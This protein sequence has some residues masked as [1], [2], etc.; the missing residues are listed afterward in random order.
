VLLPLAGCARSDPADRP[1]AAEPSPEPTEDARASGGAL[2]V[3]A[4]QPHAIDPALAVDP[5]DL[6]ITS[7]L[8]DPLTAIAPDGEVV[9]AAASRWEADEDGSVWTFH[10]RPGASFH[11]G[12]PVSAGAFADAWRRVADRTH[13]EPSPSHR[14]LGAVRGVDAA[15]EGGPLAGVEALDELTLRVT[16]DEPSVEF[17]L[18]VSHPALAP[19]PQ[20][21]TTE[22][23]F[24]RMPVGNGPFRMAEP[25]QPNQYI[26]LERNEDHPV[27]PALDH[28]VF[29]IYG[30]EDAI[31]T[32]YE[33]FA[34]GSL[35]VA[36]V[37]DTRRDQAEET[38]GR[39]PDGYQGPGLL[40]GIRS[41]SVF[42]AF[43]VTVPP[44]DQP[45]VRRAIA[46]LVDRDAL[47]RV[48]AGGGRAAA[49]SVVPPAP[50]GRATMAACPYCDVDT[51]RAVELLGE[52]DLEG[53]ELVTH[54]GGVHPQ[55][56]TRVAQ[57]VNRVLG[58]RTLR[59]RTA[60][61]ETW[62]ESVRSGEA[63]FFL[64]GW[65]PEYP[66]PAAYLE[67]LFAPDEVGGDNLTRYRNS[68]VGSLLEQARTTWDPDERAELYR[69]AEELVLADAVVIPLAFYRHG[70]VVS[71][72][73]RG[74]V[75]APSGLVDL[76]TVELD[77]E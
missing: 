28:V 22:T 3:F 15:R 27:R 57:S 62:L 13:D 64:S 37:P 50:A 43:N 56:A 35:D 44:F 48:G 60:P 23:D 63:G 20:A 70:V 33:D 72:R 1:A 8:F 17:P 46:S 65:S 76:A 29:R 14:L 47:A 42:Y 30:G 49:R 54:D 32:A 7:Q 31:D 21:A 74:Y 24:G 39:S 55:V 66:S 75:L 41:T 68:E 40:N 69:T 51:A 52:R 61:Q 4:R 71:D 67:P 36:P 2:Y 25:W 38:H 53:L 18:V 10:L 59:V 12:T 34:R 5:D 73:T 11:D 77:E 9:P 19:V 45:E 26:R 6:V 58:E 16:L